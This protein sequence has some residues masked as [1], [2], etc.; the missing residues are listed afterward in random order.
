M[1]S[2][3]LIETLQEKIQSYFGWLEER[4]I[5]YPTLAYAQPKE[6]PADA[7]DEEDE[8]I[9][10]VGDQAPA[11]FWKGFKKQ[12]YFV[13]LEQNSHGVFF[14]CVQS[15]FEQEK[16]FLLKVKSAIENHCKQSWG[17]CLLPESAQLKNQVL[18]I[19]ASNPSTKCVLLGPQIGNHFS[20]SWQEDVANSF[21]FQDSIQGEP[22]TFDYLL[23][24][25]TGSF[26][27][28][29]GLK[30]DLWSQLLDFTA[31]D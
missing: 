8:R 16:D 18:D 1:S 7:A 13:E 21:S 23:T 9:S 22:L 25:A 15:N 28:Q 26:L 4:G 3:A 11:S 5:K 30:R 31:P 14:A 17:L 27:T 24:Y 29:P 6:S 2:G 19:I 10:R 12:P 20:D